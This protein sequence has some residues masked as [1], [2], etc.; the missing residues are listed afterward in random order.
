MVIAYPHLSCSGE[1]VGVAT[2]VGILPHALCP[3]REEVYEFVERVLEEAASVFPSKFIHIGSDEVLAYDW[4]RCPRCRRLAKE[5]DLS[6]KEGLHRYF[7]ERANRI[8]QGHGRRMMAWDEVTDFAPQDVV[9]QAWRGRKRARVA[10]GRGFQ[11]LCSPIQ[12]TYLNYSRLL[13]PLRKSYLFEPVP[14]GLRPEDECC[15]VGGGANMWG[16]YVRSEADLDRHLFPRLLALAEVYWS[17][18]DARDYDEFKRRLAPIRRD[19]ESRGVEFGDVGLTMVGDTLRMARRVVVAGAHM[20]VERLKQSPLS[21][22]IKIFEAAMGLPQSL[23]S[24][25]R[26]R[27]PEPS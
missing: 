19:L 15:I 26:G 27:S 7:V 9:V 13:L 21:M 22:P 4:E 3:A 25:L 17:P 5:M 20:L 18:V 1:R 16:N 2:Q 11:T 8:V 12:E 23:L 6:G 24:P 14:P 10:M